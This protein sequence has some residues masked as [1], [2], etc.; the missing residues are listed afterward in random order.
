MKSPNHKRGSCI[1]IDPSRYGTPEQFIARTHKAAPRSKRLVT[2]WECNNCGNSLAS[3]RGV[4]RC[5]RCGS[6]EVVRVDAPVAEH[7]AFVPLKPVAYHEEGD[8]TET[9]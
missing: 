7:Q 5:P 8:D 4:S 3:T 6:L 1:V 2:T 9:E